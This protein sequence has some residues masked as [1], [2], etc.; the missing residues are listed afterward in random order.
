MPPLFANQDLVEALR[1]QFT[2][3][4]Y[5]LNPAAVAQ[6]PAVLQKIDVGAIRNQY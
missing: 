3:V 5:V 1:R 4:C 6:H 2:F